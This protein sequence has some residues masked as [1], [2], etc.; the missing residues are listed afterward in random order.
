MSPLSRSFLL[1]NGDVTL[2]SGSLLDI[3]LLNSFDPLGQTFDIMDYN[4]LTGQ[5][6][7]GSSFWDDGYLW[8]INYG[9]NQIDVTAVQAPE[10][11][12][13]LQLFIGLA[14][15]AFFAHRKMDKTQR[16]A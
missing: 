7:N 14:A 8:D 4:A 10:P 6:S 1:V 13:L 12:S 3:T 5:F 16:L 11:S 2:D 9:Q 15:L